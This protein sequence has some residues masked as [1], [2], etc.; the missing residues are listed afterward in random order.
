MESKTVEYKREFADAIKYAVTAFA[1]TDGGKIYIGIEDHGNICGVD[2][3]D[4]TLLR[5]ANMIRDAIRPDVTMFVE[6]SVSDM[7]GKQIVEISVLRGTARPY[8]LAGKGIRPEGVYIRQGASSV[9][10]SESVILDMIKET[11]GDRYENARALNQQ[12]SFKAAAT[13]FHNKDL[14]KR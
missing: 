2:D 5:T 6:C 9:P 13:F 7:D 3:V 11:G 8:Y 1:N 4:M 14:G 10:A 12:L